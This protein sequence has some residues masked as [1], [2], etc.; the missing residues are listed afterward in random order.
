MF[1]ISLPERAIISF[2]PRS[3][4]G[5]AIKKAGSQESCYGVD[6]CPGRQ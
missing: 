1:P 3:M 5:E 6:M 2:N 4:W